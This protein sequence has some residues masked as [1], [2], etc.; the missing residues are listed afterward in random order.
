MPGLR[1]RVIEVICKEWPKRED[2]E[3]ELNAVTI[4]EQLQKAGDDEASEDAVRLE[5]MHLVDH[6]LITTEARPPGADIRTIIHVSPE[7]CA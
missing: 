3:T 2:R 4:S 1:E 6:N 5:L 7:L